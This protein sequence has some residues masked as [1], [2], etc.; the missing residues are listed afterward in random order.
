MQI[1]DVDRYSMCAHR[2][3]NGETEK[4]YSLYVYVCPV[5]FLCQQYSTV[6]AY[7]HWERGRNMFWTN[8]AAKIRSTLLQPT[9]WSCCCA[10]GQNPIS[11][12]LRKRNAKQEKQKKF[13]INDLCF[14]GDDYLSFAYSSCC[15]SL[16]IVFT[17]CTLS[18]F[19]NNCMIRLGTSLTWAFVSPCPSSTRPC[20]PS[21]NMTFGAQ[22]VW[23]F[24]RL[25]CLAHTDKTDKTVS[26]ITA[27]ASIIRLHWIECSLHCACL[28]SAEI[29]SMAHSSATTVD[30]LLCH[31]FVIVSLWLE[32]ST[33][34]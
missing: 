10:R 5:P 3:R 31:L 13:L 14:A 15:S 9:I 27:P 21:H 4:G 11:F 29:S 16:Y 19:L 34:S 2:V 24:R 18:R 28:S 1:L 23:P 8:A 26:Q 7:F 20:L 33:C 25:D 12:S 30:L 22:I 32:R 6:E 17:L